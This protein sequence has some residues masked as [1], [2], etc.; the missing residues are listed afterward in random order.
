MIYQ[1][2][3]MYAKVKDE[4]VFC[5]EIYFYAEAKTLTVCTDSVDYEFTLTK[6]IKYKDK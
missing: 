6:T 2:A 5:G 4:K 3:D 1:D